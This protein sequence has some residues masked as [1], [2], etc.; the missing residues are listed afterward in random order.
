MPLLL[1]VLLGRPRILLRCGLGCI[2]LLQR[3]A[4]P[5]SE[6]PFVIT[7]AE[8]NS[9]S[10]ITSALS[11]LQLDHIHLREQGTDHDEI[12]FHLIVIPGDYLV[13]TRVPKSL[14][15]RGPQVAAED[16]LLLIA[17]F[18]QGRNSERAQQNQQETSSHD[19]PWRKMILATGS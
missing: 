8:T 1:G 17:R 18:G 11:G 9:E 5:A 19:V 3:A 2:E 15:D 13:V 10:Q 12:R 14:G 16:G 7:P 4:H 6:R